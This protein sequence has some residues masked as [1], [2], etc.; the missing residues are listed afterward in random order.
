LTERL[1]ASGRAVVTYR[2]FT[3]E[4]VRGERTCLLRTR[5][6]RVF[7]SVQGGKWVLDYDAYMIYWSGIG[8]DNLEPVEISE[9]EALAIAPGR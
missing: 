2:F 5:D 8:G 6:G 3:L 7:E 9:A 1:D 4:D